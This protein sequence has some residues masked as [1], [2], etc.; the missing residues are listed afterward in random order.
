MYNPN[1]WIIFLSLFL[2]NFFSYSQKKQSYD[3]LYSNSDLF[4]FNAVIQENEVHFGT[5]QGV[6]IYKDNNPLIRNESITGAI[7]I[8]DGAINKG[9]VRYDNSYNYLLPSD[10]KRFQT[11]HLARNE[12]LYII[13]KGDLFV[14]KKSSYTFKRFPSIR[15]ISENYL[16]TYGGIYN[17]SGEKLQF[18]T[19][20]GNK[21]KEYD[22]LTIINWDGL[23][24]IDREKQQDYYYPDVNIGGIEI[25][26]EL[27]GN[28]IDSY[29]LTH[30]NYLLSTSKGLYDFNA[31]S[32][33][34]KQLIPSQGKPF[35][36]IRGERNSSGLKVLYLFNEEEIFEYYVE[37][38]RINSLTSYTEIKDVFS[39]TGS[40]YY[41]LTNSSLDFFSI[42]EPSKNRRIREDLINPNNVLLFKNF[43][44]ITSDQ[45]LDLMDL[46]SNKFAKN[47]IRDELNYNA[48]FKNDSIVKLGS[49]NG[50]YELDYNDLVVL[51]D[52]NQPLL[53]KASTNIWPYV[54]GTIIV[55]VIFSIL[56]M[57]IFN[58]QK[59]IKDQRNLEA[60]NTKAK[61]EEFIRLN[62]SKVNVQLLSET[63]NLPI[64]SLYTILGN[65]KPGEIIRKERL[66]IVRV[67]RRKKATEEEISK[68][69]GFSISYLKKI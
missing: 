51:F 19:Y 69:T 41:I 2:G 21:I 31:G 29:E 5:D 17:K 56:L 61:I 63:F 68:A 16:G 46:N 43:I 37:E 47:V 32:K 58:Q 6:V 18:P 36:F 60:L 28:A 35:R 48:I 44:L 65:K 55:T 20:T 53:E 59:L 9:S 38:N 40:E 8:E 50:L 12:F 4:Y 25:K 13:C 42:R 10:Y 49:V 26:N 22:S 15:S 30:P 57:V 23:S 7:Q 33:E 45:G 66:R 54:L 1:Y 24:I 27:F 39:Q 52:T 34:I 14:F 67:M 3:F 11:F 64:N 62:I